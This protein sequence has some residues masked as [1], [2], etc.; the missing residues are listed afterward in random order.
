M[1]RKMC[2]VFVNLEMPDPKTSWLQ[3]IACLLAVALIGII[4]FAMLFCAPII[5]R[6]IRELTDAEKAY[7]EERFRYHG[8]EAAICE[9]EVCYFY[10]DGRK[11][12]L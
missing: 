7:F 1:L 12:R 4:M 5:E 2:G 10:R 11:C 9:G 3:M 6:E 8:I